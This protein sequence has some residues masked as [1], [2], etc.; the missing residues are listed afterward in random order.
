MWTRVQLLTSKFKKAGFKNNLAHHIET[1]ET[2]CEEKNI[3][4]NTEEEKICLTYRRTKKIRI[5]FC[6]KAYKK[7]NK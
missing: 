2:K 1:A 5:N 7:K 6:Q 4:K 3:E